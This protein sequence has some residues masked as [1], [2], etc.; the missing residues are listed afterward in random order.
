MI[1]RWT[2]NDIIL[3]LGNNLLNEIMLPEKWTGINL[4]P[5]PN[6]VALVKLEIT[7]EITEI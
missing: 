6:L 4:L 2:L 7:E 3:E 1:K 5:I